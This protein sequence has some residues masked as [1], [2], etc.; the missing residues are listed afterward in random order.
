MK[1]EYETEILHWVEARQVV[2]GL[3]DLRGEQVTSGECLSLVQTS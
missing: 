3:Y 1:V 2:Q